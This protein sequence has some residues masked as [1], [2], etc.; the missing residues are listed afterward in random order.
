MVIR[1]ISDIGL[2]R[3]CNEDSC[4]YGYF[5]DTDGFVVVCDGMGGASGGKVASTICSSTVA[6][7]IRKGYRPKMTV[8]AAR[9]LLESAITKANY[10][11]YEKSQSDPYLHGMG[12]TIVVAIIIKNIAVIANVGDS[13][14]YILNEQGI[15]QITKDHSLVQL[16]IDEGKITADEAKTH[17]DRNIITRAV[18]VV[19][20][21]DVDFEIVDF[22]TGD[23]L[24]LCTDGLCGSVEAEELFGIVS[25]DIN[26]STEKLVERALENGSKDNI[27][28]ALVGA[29]G[30][31]E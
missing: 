13:R 7:A 10:Q 27:T 23:K 22:K 14:A 28:V 9:N 30:Q 6:D 3:E 1:A 15:K 25:D 11:V 20:F 5:G 31:G 17:P 12:T 8:K 24:L 21:V 29:D 4:E 26:F 19:N 2:F 16:M 18:G